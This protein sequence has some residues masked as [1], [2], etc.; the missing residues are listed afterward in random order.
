MNGVREIQMDDNRGRRIDF[1]ARKQAKEPLMMCVAV[2]DGLAWMVVMI[3]RSRNEA[4]LQERESA[5]ERHFLTQAMSEK[6]GFPRRGEACKN[7]GSPTH[8]PFLHAYRPKVYQ[9][10]SLRVFMK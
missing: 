4:I 1:A 7:E 2:S 9:L 8:L 5:K 10:V 3:F 6:C